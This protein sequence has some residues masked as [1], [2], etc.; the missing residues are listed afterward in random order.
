MKPI[1]LI[2]VSLL[3]I[4]TYALLPSN[5][6]FAEETGEI[7]QVEK[8]AVKENAAPKFWAKEV[9]QKY[10]LTDEQIQNLKQAKIAGPQLAITA[11]L[12]KASGKTVEEISKMRTDEKMGWGAIAKKLGVAPST[13]GKS[14]AA[15]RHDIRDKR[16]DLRDDKRKERKEARRQNHIERSRGSDHSKA[17]N[18]S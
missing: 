2:L 6:A 13:I 18:R 10:N 17:R 14:V 8:D 11:E 7:E 15:V 9:Q 4:T 5:L 12:A 3:L 1:K 16:A